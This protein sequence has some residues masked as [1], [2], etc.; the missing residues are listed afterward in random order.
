MKNSDLEYLAKK[1]LSDG[2]ELSDAD[3]I[4]LGNY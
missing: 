4:L 3:L 1:I 2:W